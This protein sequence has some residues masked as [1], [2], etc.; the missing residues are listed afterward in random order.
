MKLDTLKLLHDIYAKYSRT[1]W[2]IKESATL[3]GHTVTIEYMLHHPLDETYAHLD[4]NDIIIPKASRKFFDQLESVY[5]TSLEESEWAGDVQYD[6]NDLYEA[7]LKFFHDL[8]LPKETRDYIKSIFFKN[9]KLQSWKNV[10]K[11]YDPT[12]T[13]SVVTIRISSD[14][15]AVLRKGQ[16]IE[17]G[18]QR[19]PIDTIRKIVETYDNL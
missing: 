14:Y 3:L 11:E 16:S 18:C 9:D 5:G 2:L 13:S 7:E 1:K 6:R 17:V 10:E 4:I 8:R 15:S 12:G 19:I